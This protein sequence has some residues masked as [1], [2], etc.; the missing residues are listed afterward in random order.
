MS[1][2][3]R[4]RKKEKILFL[5]SHKIMAMVSNMAHMTNGSVFF[6]QSP[7][8]FPVRQFQTWHLL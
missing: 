6:S 5:V 7:L 3:Y 8:R 4:E 2:K 1:Q